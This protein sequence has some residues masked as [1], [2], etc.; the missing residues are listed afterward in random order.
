MNSNARNAEIF[1]N[2]SVF[3][4]AA[5]TRALAPAAGKMTAK[6]SFPSFHPQDPTQAWIWVVLKLPDLA[7]PAAVFREPDDRSRAL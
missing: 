3:V 5:K 6:S 2:P 4:Q 7:H 1:T